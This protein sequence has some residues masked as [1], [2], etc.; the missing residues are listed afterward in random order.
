[1]CKVAHSQNTTADILMGIIIPETAD[2]QEQ[3]L[4]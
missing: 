3:I 4:I 2:Y 1:M